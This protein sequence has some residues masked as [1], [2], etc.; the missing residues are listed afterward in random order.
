MEEIQLLKQEIEKLKERNKCL[1]KGN[2]FCSHCDVL[3]LDK[4][5]EP[6][7]SR[8]NVTECETCDNFFCNVCDKDEN[9]M[10]TADYSQHWDGDYCLKCR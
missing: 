6:E 10:A 2:I 5:G 7:T 8:Y 9:V 3:I 1:V 4:D